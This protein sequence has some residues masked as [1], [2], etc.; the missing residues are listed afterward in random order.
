M[1]TID[2]IIEITNRLDHLEQSAEWIA[3]E[4]VHSD[5]AVSQTGS[6]MCV[7]AEDIRDK[8]CA[9]VKLLEKK[10]EHSSYH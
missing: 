2:K 9:L 8:L 1:K 6:L 7:L 3:R 5:N 4:T 10:V